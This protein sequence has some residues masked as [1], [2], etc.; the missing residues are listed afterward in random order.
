MFYLLI[1]FLLTLKVTKNLLDEAEI[2]LMQVIL[3]NGT[4]SLG[5]VFGGF[6]QTPC[7]WV[8]SG[9]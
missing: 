5:T 7:E 4:E 3:S 6:L 8:V 9:T 1:N 2:A